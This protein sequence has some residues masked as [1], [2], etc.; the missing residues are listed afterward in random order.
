MSSYELGYRNKK[1][2]HVKPKKYDECQNNN[3]VYIKN[4][5]DMPWHVSTVFNWG[6]YVYPL[7]IPL[8]NIACSMRLAA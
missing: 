6:R 3:N 2:H 5:R 1:Y 7:A 4:S 8:A